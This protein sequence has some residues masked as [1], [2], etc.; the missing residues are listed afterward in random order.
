MA[1]APGA[2]PRTRAPGPLGAR[3]GA[4]GAQAH[5]GPSIKA[6]TPGVLWVCAVGALALGGGSLSTPGQ[7]RA[8][9]PAGRPSW[10]GGAGNRALHGRCWGGL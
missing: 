6:V 4:L 9:A 1:E 10:K 8:M 3:R 5:S 2:L 7:L